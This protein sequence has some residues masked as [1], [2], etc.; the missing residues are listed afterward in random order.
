MFR[1]LPNRAPTVANWAT[2]FAV[3]VFTILFI[4]LIRVNP[5]PV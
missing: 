4:P 3:V 1:A 2:G 5:V